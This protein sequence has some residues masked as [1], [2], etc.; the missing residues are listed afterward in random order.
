MRRQRAAA[1]KDGLAAAGRPP[2]LN[3]VPG[4][5]RAERRESSLT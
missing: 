2:A 5:V 4:G 1:P 3:D